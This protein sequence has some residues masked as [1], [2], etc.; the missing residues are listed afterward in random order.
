VY[1]SNKQTNITPSEQAERVS[2]HVHVP[3]QESER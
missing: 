1:Q 3:S 2:G